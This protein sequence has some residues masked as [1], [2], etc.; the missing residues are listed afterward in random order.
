MMHDSYIKLESF[1]VKFIGVYTEKMRSIEERLNH[2]GLKK[3]LIDESNQE[4]LLKDQEAKEKNQMLAEKNANLK[5]KHILN[6]EKILDLQKKL[7]SHFETML[8]IKKTQKGLSEEKN[9][10]LKR[11]MLS[12]NFE[13][14]QDGS[15]SV[16]ASTKKSKKTCKNSGKSFC[17]LE[18]LGSKKKKTE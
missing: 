12:V 1:Y 11:R 7:N 9:F 2:I 10:I 18:C 15:A 14:E 16:K 3:T 13:M 17:D 5:A 8:E 4:L 6:K